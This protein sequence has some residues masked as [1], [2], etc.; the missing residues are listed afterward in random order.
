MSKAVAKSCLFSLQNVV[1]P[2]HS[3]LLSFRLGWGGGVTIQSLIYA[4]QVSEQRGMDITMQPSW[5]ILRFQTFDRD[6]GS[7]NILF[8]F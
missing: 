6:L 5:S 4:R 8:S 3:L 2:L 7:V 1:F